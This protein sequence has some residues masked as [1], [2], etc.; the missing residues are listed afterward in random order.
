MTEQAKEISKEDLFKQIQV[1]TYQF[2]HL[3]LLVSYIVEKN[4][5]SSKD[6]NRWIA[7]T[8]KKA[9]KRNETK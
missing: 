4:K 5:L 9:D 6:Y 8:N 3:Q 2:N 1:L 7:K